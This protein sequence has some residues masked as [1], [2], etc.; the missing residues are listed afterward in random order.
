MQ[1]SD[2]TADHRAHVFEGSQRIMKITDEVF[3]EYLHCK[4]MAYLILT[5]VVREPSDYEQ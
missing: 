3:T 1:L 2:R 4:Y 5:G